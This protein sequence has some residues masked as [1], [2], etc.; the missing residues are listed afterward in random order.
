MFTTTL[1]IV[2]KRM[3]LAMLLCQK[4]DVVPEDVEQYTVLLL[5][6]SRPV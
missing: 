5:L 1:P 4:R 6:W 3:Y 2:L